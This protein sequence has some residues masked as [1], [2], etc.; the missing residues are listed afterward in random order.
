[1][2]FEDRAEAG[3]AL[4]KKLERYAGRPDVALFAL[5]RGGVVTG[6]EVAKVLKLPLG[7]IVTRKIG[8]P[9]NPEYALGALA[10]TGEMLWGEEG[11]AVAED[12]D[13][14]KIVAE[15]KA[16]A[17]RRIT[18]Y[19]H[20]SPLPDLRGKTAVI[21]DDGIATGLTMRAAVAA[22]RHQRAAEIVVAVPHGAKDSLRQLRREVDEVVALDEPAWYGA[23]GAFYKDFPQTSDEEVLSLLKNYG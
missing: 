20:G 6:A 21:V 3:R 9:Y 23:V 7:I 1:M 10:E 14:K 15:E 4:A 18:K 19:R 8:A 2:I 16:E 5:P 22:A 12:A 13:V 11:E 17:A